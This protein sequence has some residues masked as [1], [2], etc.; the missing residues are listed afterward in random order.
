[1]AEL[2]FLTAGVRESPPFA[3]GDL[4]GFE[5]RSKEGEKRVLN[6]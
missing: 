3:K 1:M 2:A 6:Q 5:R 4:G